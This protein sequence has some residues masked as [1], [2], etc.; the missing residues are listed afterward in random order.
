MSSESHFPDYLLGQNQQNTPENIALFEASLKGDVH[1]VKALLN[2]GAKPNFF[3]RPEDQKNA[4]H[5]AAENAHSEV[6]ELL[7]SHGAVVNAIAS[8]D[9][10]T[11]L[12]LAAHHDNNVTVIE[13]LLNAG[14]TIGAENGYGN[15]ALHEACHH[16]NLASARVLI[17][18]GANPNQ[19]NHKGSTSLHTFCYGE[20]CATHTLD[21]LR[22]LIENG[23]DVD[24]EDN[25][26][27]TPLLVACS[28]GRYVEMISFNNYVLID[29]LIRID[30]I[31]ELI[32]NG[33]KISSRDH[34]HRGAR[35][36]AQF[37]KQ[38]G[39]VEYLDSR[40]DS[41]GLDYKHK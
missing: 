36:T 23:A 27:V 9:K 22:F 26:G 18:A 3:Y 35:E 13:K 15:T 25:R 5:V 24:I 16:G 12:V 32:A 30:L 8:T 29:S 4:L 39:V 6:V 37:Y 31:E 2:K 20:S 38:Q 19:R 1:Q 7:L 21:M 10:S 34:N 33:A 14:A 11:P 28:S 41:K 17:R 40:S